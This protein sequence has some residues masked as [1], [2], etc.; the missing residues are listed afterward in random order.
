M[1]HRFQLK[2]LPHHQLMMVAGIADKDFKVWSR[3]S[4][5]KCC[6]QFAMFPICLGMNDSMGTTHS[7]SPICRMNSKSR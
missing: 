3:F 1:M 2:C 7:Q 4:R 5:K 6:D